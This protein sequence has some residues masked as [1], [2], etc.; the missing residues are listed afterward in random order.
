[1]RLVLALVVSFIAVTG[2]LVLLIYKMHLDQQAQYQRDREHFAALTQQLDKQNTIEAQAQAGLRRA[3]ADEAAAKER[4]TAATAAEAEAKAAADAEAQRKLEAEAA[5]RT[6]E[7]EARKAAA[8]AKSKKSTDDARRNADAKRKEADDAAKAE[9][10]ARE[11]EVRERKKRER[12]EAARLR[13]EQRR[14]RDAEAAERAAERARRLR[15]EREALKQKRAE[16]AKQADED[17]QADAALER[18][19]AAERKKKADAAKKA[20]EAREAAEAKKAAE[21]KAAEEAKLAAAA[22]DPANKCPKGMTLIDAGSFMMGAPRNDPE[23]NF[24]D[25]TYQSMEVPAYCIDYYESPNGR[26]RTPSSSVSQKTAVKMCKSRGKRLCEEHEWE[27]ACKGPSGL[28]YPYGNQ[29]DPARCGTEDD[30]GNDRT[31]AKSGTY[32]RCRSGYNVFDLSGNVAEWT[33]TKW[34]SG[35]VVKGGS[36]DRPGYDGRCAARKKKSVSYSSEVIGFRC[37]ADPL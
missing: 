2:A 15:E 29:W 12:E 23:R 24:G 31:V 5:A 37:C 22:A 36:A 13:A 14:E 27:K 3:S 9:K 26:G 1:M 18:A 32:R 34:S 25:Q 16:A 19:E 28:R 30:E 20:E 7:D 4:V 11:R 33:A 6:A 21:A 35:Y 8:E 10:T 17:K